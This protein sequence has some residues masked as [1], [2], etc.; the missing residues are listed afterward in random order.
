MGKLN[1]RNE[2][3]RKRVAIKNDGSKLTNDEL[4]L[5][6]MLRI[7]DNTELMAG[8]FIKMQKNIQSLER[9]VEFYRSER[10]RVTKQLQVQK[11]LNTR[12]RKKL[13]AAVGLANENAKTA[14][15]ASGS[16]EVPSV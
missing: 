14:A 12:L 7:A 10:D 9:S 2:T 16:E 15:D 13:D 1:Y 5:G 4:I 11:G 6:C 8:N 3:K